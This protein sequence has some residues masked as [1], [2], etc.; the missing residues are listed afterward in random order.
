M[1]GMEAAGPGPSQALPTQGKPHNG[2]VPCMSGPVLRVQQ[3]FVE[4]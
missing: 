2:S 3:G 4:P 1:S